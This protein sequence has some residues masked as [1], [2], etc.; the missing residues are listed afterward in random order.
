[1][2]LTILIAQNRFLGKKIEDGQI[3]IY[4]KIDSLEFRSDQKIA[5]V[6]IKIVDHET[7]ITRI[8]TVQDLKNNGTCLMQS[9]K[10]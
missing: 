8:E 4:D 2:I 3:R 7:R 6:D 5:N 9:A 1:M 10:N